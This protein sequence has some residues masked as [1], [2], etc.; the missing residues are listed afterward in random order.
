MRTEGVAPFLPLASSWR[1]AERNHVRTATALGSLKGTSIEEMMG[2][3]VT[4]R[5]GATPPKEADAFDADARLGATS[6]S[7]LRPSTSPS[8][9][10]AAGITPASSHSAEFAAESTFD[11]GPETDVDALALRATDARADTRALSRATSVEVALEEAD[12]EL[13]G[14]EFLRWVAPEELCGRCHS[15]RA[16]SGGFSCHRCGGTEPPRYLRLSTASTRQ[17]QLTISGVSKRDVIDTADLLSD[18]PIEVFVYHAQVCVL[19]PPGSWRRRAPLE[20]TW[21]RAVREAAPYARALGGSL[22][23]YGGV[24]GKRRGNETPQASAHL[25]SIGE[26]VTAVNAD[27]HFLGRTIGDSQDQQ[28]LC[29]KIRSMLTTLVALA[30]DKIHKITTEKRKATF[31][32]VPGASER[33]GT[34][35]GGFRPGTSGSSARPGTSAAGSRARAI[36]GRAR[37]PAGRARAIAGRHGRRPAAGLER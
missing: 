2:C 6:R 36:A 25:Q 26:L 16:L 33:P 17:R 14:L 13:P 1:A 35:S 32:D 10:A 23:G 3:R 9:L 11:H 12:G 29:A 20:D 28:L 22:G 30:E 5:A 8:L 4:S 37:A 15:M 31:D 19:A 18:I 27:P 24:V 7:T 34:G 21:W